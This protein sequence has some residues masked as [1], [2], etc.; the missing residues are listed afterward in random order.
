MDQIEH[1]VVVMLEN[2]S[3]D[4][5]LGWLYTDTDNHPSHTIPPQA[6]PSYEG[7]LAHTYYNTTDDAEAS[8]CYVKKSTSRWPPHHEPLLVPLPDPGEA[9]E[10]ITHQIFGTKNPEPDAKANMSGFLRDYATIADPAVVGQIMESYSPD[11]APVIN[12]LAR[13]FAV[14]DRWF[15]SVPCQTW[16]NRGFVHSGS[17]AG[18]INNG[19]YVPYDIATIFNV[20]QDQG[21]TW[22]VFSD[23]IYTPALAG[24]Q[25]S[26]LWSF[27][28]QFQSF[29]AFQQLCQAPVNASAAEK[30]PAYS[31]IEPRFMLEW[32]PGKTYYANDYHCSHNI[33]FGEAFLAEV[34]TA[35][36]HSP[37]RDQILLIISFDEHGGC[38]DHVPPPA[39]AA[40]PEP[41]A[42][43]TDGD[44]HF[45]RFGVRV[46]TIVVSSYVK[47]GTV[48]RT[49][50]AETPYD[51]TSILGHSENITMPPSEL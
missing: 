36:Q 28:E 38:Y 23:T 43:A 13:N 16:P 31:F 15:A 32:T 30:L 5:L 17:S 45:D 9:F 4:N 49:A 25:F 47:P 40:P 1:V 18:H 21:L 14:C 11:Q 42:I 33:A 26:Q 8:R 48:F 37:Y 24:V 19:D 46:P 44:F 7:L 34:Y 22:G 3:F 2:R 35:V 27:T 51:H 39:N 29:S 10:H 50:Q 20:L 12:G 6:E 41:G